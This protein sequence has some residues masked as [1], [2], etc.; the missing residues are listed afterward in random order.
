MARSSVFKKTRQFKAPA[1]VLDW[2][3]CG[4]QTRYRP[5]D[6]IYSC[7]MRG[8]LPSRVVDVTAEYDYVVERLER[9]CATVLEP[10]RMHIMS[11]S[12]VFVTQSDAALSPERKD[13]MLQ[14]ARQHERTFWSAPNAAVRLWVLEDVDPDEIGCELFGQTPPPWDAERMKADLRRDDVFCLVELRPGTGA[15]WSKRYQFS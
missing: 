12:S 10:G 9:D 15:I 5:G 4:R 11:I 13:Q 1:G 2:L 8:P 6:L 7:R 3:C 14:L